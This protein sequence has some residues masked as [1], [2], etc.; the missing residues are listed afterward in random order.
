MFNNQQTKTEK[1]ALTFWIVVSACLIIVS[2]I[3]VAIG[4][5]QLFL[6]S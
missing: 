5:S 1:I 2:A 6:P 3:A 4:I